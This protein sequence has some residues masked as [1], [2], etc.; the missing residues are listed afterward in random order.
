MSTQQTISNLFKKPF[1]NSLSKEVND[2]RKQQI[3]QVNYNLTLTITKTDSYYGNVQIDF[4][5]TK[6]LENTDVVFDFEGE[7]LWVEVNDTTFKNITEN[8]YQGKFFR[9][10]AVLL[11]LGDYNRINVQFKNKYSNDG[12]GLHSYTDPTDSK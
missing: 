6:N 3:S 5:R 10:P 7:L 2:V 1:A 12:C 8:L 4:F 11:K 9:I